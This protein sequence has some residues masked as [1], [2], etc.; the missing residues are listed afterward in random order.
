MELALRYG[1]YALTSLIPKVPAFAGTRNTCIRAYRA[2]AR[3]PNLEQWNGLQHHDL[4]LLS[5]DMLG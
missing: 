3:R 2:A 1:R 4:L 5:S